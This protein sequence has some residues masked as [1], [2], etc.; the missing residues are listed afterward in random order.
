MKEIK[1]FDKQ[2][3]LDISVQE[4][5]GVED[6]FLILSHNNV[7]LDKPLC[8]SSKLTIPISDI[9]KGDV[10]GYL[11]KLPS[12][13]ATD[14]H[15]VTELIKEYDYHPEYYYSSWTDIVDEAQDDPF[16]GDYDYEIDLGDIIA[17]NITITIDSEHIASTD[18]VIFIPYSIQNTNNVPVRLA[19]WE[20]GTSLG[21]LTLSA[22]SVSN[23]NF[24]YQLPQGA[25]FVQTSI[26][27]FLAEYGGKSVTKPFSVVN[28]GQHISQTLSQNTIEVN[29]VNYNNG[30]IVDVPVGSYPIVIY[31]NPSPEQFII[32]R[33]IT[34]LGVTIYEP[35][36]QFINTLSNDVN[37]YHYSI[38]VVDTTRTLT[39]N[40]YTKTVISSYLATL[41]FNPISI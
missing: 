11:S 28:S 9:V 4:Y 33:K 24:E 6:V 41:T 5:G 16:D 8:L 3:I 19:V 37:L 23:P 35:M 31:S 12:L 34:E 18:S 13:I 20:G 10:T 39:F 32:R 40:F 1:I 30:D 26:H 27:L 17:S 38:G 7:G 2:D 15:K 25:S 14:S 21:D 36:S 22:N 29:G